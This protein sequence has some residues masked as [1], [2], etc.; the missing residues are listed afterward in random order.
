MATDDEVIAAALEVLRRRT[1]G[2]S[3]LTVGA[4]YE[5]YEAA[6]RRS[7]SWEYIE[8]RLRPVVATLRE[9]AVTGLRPSDWTQYATARLETPI[10]EGKPKKFDARTINAEL[11]WL[12]AMCNWGVRETLITFNPLA[13][14]RALKVRRGRE[15]APAEDEI[16]RALAACETLEQRVM[17]LC[18]ADAGMRRGEIV[19]L[20]HDWVD[21]AAKRIHLPGWACKNNKG[22]SI[23]A[24]QRLLDAIA[25]VPR[26]IRCPNV[27]VSPRGDGAFHRN[28]MNLWW[29]GIRE[30]A[31]LEAAPVDGKVH[32]HDLRHGCAT[33]AV[34]R[35][36]GIEIV[37][38]RILRHA[39]LKQTEVYVQG[40]SAA[41]LDEAIERFQAGIDRDQRRAA[42]SKGRREE[43]M[44][45]VKT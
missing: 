24:T 14:V 16:T 29:R 9:V 1:Q 18:G 25:A 5:K 35:G 26:H 38:R 34:R 13:S 36:V 37:S 40:S 7:R 2:A 12:K 41:D 42:E 22:G 8:R 11:T 23:P 39:S 20:R 45:R 3:A 43:K 4:L 30:R 21:Y 44:P 6:M 17:V 28:T 10:R 19:Q 32:L 31:G 33:N 27:F 15:T